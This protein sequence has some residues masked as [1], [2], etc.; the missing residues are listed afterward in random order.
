MI[1]LDSVT[2]RFP[3]GLVAV[4]NVSLEIKEG[5]FVVFI[6]PSGCGKTTTMKMINRLIEPTSGK[7]IVNGRDISKQD[8]IQLRRG[9]GYVI[10][11]IGLMPH[12]T[13]AENIAL[14]PNLQK[15]PKEKQKKRVE[16][17]LEMV[18]LDVAETINKYP[19]QL[20]GGQRQ[21][22]GVARALAVDPPIMLMDEP[23]GALDP[24][25]REQ[26]QDEFIKLQEKV[27]KTIVF[28][29][30]DM[31]EALKFANRIVLLNKGKIV[32]C[33]S[34]QEI[35]RN[36]ANSFVRDFVGTDHALRQLSLIKIKDAMKTDISTV[37]PKDTID[38]ARKLFKQGYRSI[39][40]VDKNKK[41]VGYIN[42]EDAEKMTDDMY[43]SDIMISPMGTVHYEKSLKE[44]LNHMLR[45]DFGYLA[46]VNDQSMLLGI[47]TSN[48][49][50]K[51]VG[52]GYMDREGA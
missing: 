1:L 33:A 32:Q 45:F 35:L 30:H 26:M 12:M 52:E 22:V 29:T 31:D 19:R 25:T 46:V 8:P 4:D 23:F 38:D 17:L 36:P 3:N 2:K 24:I 44:A 20:S 21:R 49:L 42:R 16:E 14:I 10:Q 50:Y 43:V 51:N 9:I 48:C 13:V 28:V 11:E 34:P 39:I 37:H 47:I 5:E 15:W 18:E 6:G 7:I 40:V 41:V 27:K